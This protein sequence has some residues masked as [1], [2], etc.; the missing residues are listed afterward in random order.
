M[1][2]T[3]EQQAFIKEFTPWAE[4]ASQQL[5]ISPSII[6]AQ[7]ALE[8]GWN[9]NY[10]GD[11]VH[12]VAGLTTNGT[13]L[14]VFPSYAQMVQKYVEVMRNDCPLI[15]EGK[16]SLNSTAQEVFANTRY[17]TLDSTYADTIAAIANMISSE[18]SPTSSESSPT[19]SE[20]A[21]TSSES[22]PTLSELAQSPVGTYAHLG[23]QYN[24][25][26]QLAAILWEQGIR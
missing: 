18:S 10:V 3:Q 9:V 12:N 11:N 1:A 24:V 13:N 21:S 7:W 23:T 22:A 6:L 26:Q 8:S 16:S 2:T 17:N 4:Q 20:S 14:M 19:S 25:Y 15:R 5:N